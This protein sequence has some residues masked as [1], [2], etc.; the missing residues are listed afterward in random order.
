MIHRN[1]AVINQRGASININNTTD[2]EGIQISQRSGSNILINNILN[3][4]LAT[5]N[6]QVNIVHDDFKTVGGESSEYVNKNKTIR[7]VE[8]VYNLTGFA[9]EDEINAYQSWKDTYRPVANLNSQFKIKRGGFAFPVG[10]ETKLAGTRRDNPVI[11]QK[12]YVVE[13]R[14]TGYLGIPRRLANADEVTTYVTVPDRTTTTPAS[15]KKITE[16]DIQLSAGE[17]GSNAPGV[18]EFG[19]KVIAATEDST[20]QANEPAQ[21]INEAVLAIQDQLSPIEKLMGHEGDEVSFIKRNKFENVGATF[22]DYPSVRIDEKGRSQ[23]FEM[24][25]ADTGIYKNHDYIPHVEE[26]DNSSNFP[27]GEDVKI[28]GNKYARNVGSGGISF[29]TSGV[30]ELG[31]ATLKAGY[32]KVNLNASHGIHIGSEAG[33]ELQ[34][35]KTIVLRTNRQVYVE[36]ALGVKNNLIVGGGLAVEGETYLQHVTAPLEVQQTQDTIL[37]GK[38]ATDVNRRLVIGECE[39]GGNWYNVYAVAGDNLIVNYPHSHHFHNI[40]LTL[41]RANKDVR[42]L[43]QANGINVHNNLS[44]ASGQ[45][46]Q[47]KG[48]VEVTNGFPVVE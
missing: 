4:E 47:R 25:V 43:A 41:G 34:S 1:K 44:Q 26:V 3:S 13:N 8:N 16:G 11:G 28:V 35:L 15:E 39:I 33:I 2:Q 24:L 30:M 36:S 40:P 42:K 20:W 10:D 7:V 19:A 29:K 46:H 14:F 6:K 21:K 9:T 22:N 12:V 37:A 45:L 23:P 27:C 32:K 17:T 48:P 31:G 38:F 5:N 18:L